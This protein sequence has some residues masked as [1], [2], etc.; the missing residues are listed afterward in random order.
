MILVRFLMWYES[1]ESVQTEKDGADW[2]FLV[3]TAV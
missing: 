1:W 2:F 3:W